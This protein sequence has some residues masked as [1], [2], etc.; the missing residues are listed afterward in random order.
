M[1]A[2]GAN[3]C[4]SARV[5]G[6][7]TSP[8]SVTVCRDASWLGSLQVSRITLHGAASRCQCRSRCFQLESP[9]LPNLTMGSYV[10]VSRLHSGTFRTWNWLGTIM[11]KTTRWR[12]IS[13]RSWSGS[14]AA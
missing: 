5:A 9:T 10:H 4:A 11:R 12:S 7:R 14:F 3:F 13:A 8:P 6:F 1:A 2:C